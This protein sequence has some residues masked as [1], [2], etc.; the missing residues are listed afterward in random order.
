MASVTLSPFPAATMTTQRPAA[1]ACIK[2]SI[3]GG[4]GLSDDR[5]AAL[6]EA[7]S[8]LVERFAPDAPDAIKNEAVIRA[9]GWI[10]AREPRPIQSIGLDTIKLDFRE[11]FFRTARSH[12][13]R[14]ASDAAPMASAPRPADRGHVMRWPWAKR[15]PE[16]RSTAQGYTA[17]LTAAFATGATEGVSDTAPLAT[18]AL[19]AAA[20][21]YGQ[22]H[23]CGRGEGCPDDV[24]DALT[25][26][27]LAL[28]ARNLIRRGEDH[29]RIYVRGGRLVSG[30]GGIR[31][32]ARQRAG[33]DGVDVQRH[34]L[35]ADGLPA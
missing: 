32:R 33:P 4:A 13:F 21:L 15:E 29:H 35:R 3:S 11:R 30:A 19:E 22:M 25:A 16:Q 12:Q 17:S 7:A 31:L 8:A 5:A 20:G 26:P 1:I 27:V 10:H 23:G 28:I 14:G 6:G 24:A 2:S 34:V 18:A 9:A